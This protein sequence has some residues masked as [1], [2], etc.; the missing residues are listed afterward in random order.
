MSHYL[1]GSSLRRRVK[2]PFACTLIN[3]VVWEVHSFE[4]RVIFFSEGVLIS[5]IIWEGHCV[6]DVSR[7]LSFEGHSM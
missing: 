5:L 4:G 2:F 1:D 6:C 7:K 3:F